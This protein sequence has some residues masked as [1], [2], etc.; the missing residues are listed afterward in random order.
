MQRY[1]TLRYDMDDDISLT[2]WYVSQY[3]VLINQNHKNNKILPL[4]HS[5]LQ[6]VFST[7]SDGDLDYLLFLKN[8]A[9][10]RQRIEKLKAEFY[11]VYVHEICTK[12]ILWT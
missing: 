6:D 12:R 5:H 9:F 1:T 2:I 11:H 10:R 8:K 7:Y 3:A 4:L